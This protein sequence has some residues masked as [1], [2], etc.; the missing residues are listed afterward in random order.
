MHYQG[1]IPAPDDFARFEDI[2]P[3]SADRIMTLTERQTDHRMRLESSVVASQQAQSARGQ[4]FA[5]LIGLYGITAGAYVA[6]QGHD[7]VGGGI[8]GTTVISLVYTFVTGKRAQRKDLSEKARSLPNP[9]E[10]R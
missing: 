8:A 1:P 10:S 2:L 4:W 6:L 5:F 3:G 9:P 7:W